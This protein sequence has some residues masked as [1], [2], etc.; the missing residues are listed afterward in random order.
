[1]LRVPQGLDYKR[2]KV[3]NSTTVSK[4]YTN[5]KS[6]YE[7]HNYPPNCVWNVDETSCEAF[8]GGLTKVFAKRCVKGIHKV[9]LAKRKWQNVFSAINANDECIPNYYIFKGFRKLR[10]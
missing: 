10:N 9:I 2:A 3:V 4:F 1:M 6:L 7:E 5:L 8:H